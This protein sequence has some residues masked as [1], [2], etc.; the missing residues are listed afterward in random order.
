MDNG[1]LTYILPFFLLPSALTP[2][3]QFLLTF[4][5]GDFSIAIA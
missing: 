3:Q 5:G 4:V 1:L 2:L